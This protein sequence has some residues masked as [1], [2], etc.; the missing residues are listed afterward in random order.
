MTVF[1]F[2]QIEKIGIAE[3]EFGREFVLVTRLVS[4]SGEL[5]NHSPHSLS[6]KADRL[7]FLKWQEPFSLEAN[8]KK[9]SVADSN[10]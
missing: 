6:Y 2:Q 8:G 5:R 9:W 10:R 4:T 7:D 3:G 1:K